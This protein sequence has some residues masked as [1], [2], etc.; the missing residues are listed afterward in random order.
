MNKYSQTLGRKLTK[1]ERKIIKG[2]NSMVK[3]S[4]AT[5]NKI[6]EYFGKVPVYFNKAAA[7]ELPDFVKVQSGIPF[8]RA[9]LHAL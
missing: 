5:K 6:A 4:I 8:V 2:G 7:H 9:E 3:R 1:K